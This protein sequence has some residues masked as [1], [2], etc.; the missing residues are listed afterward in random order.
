MKPFVTKTDTPT[1]ASASVADRNAPFLASHAVWA[2]TIVMVFVFTMSAWSILAP[3]SSAIVAPGVVSVE[4]HRKAVQHLEGGIVGRILVKEGTRVKTGDVLVELKDVAIVASFERLKSQYYETLAITAR[5]TSERDGLEN[6]E[7]G[8]ELIAASSSEAQARAAMAAQ[9]KIFSSRR[10]LKAERLSVLDKRIRRLEE[11]RVGARNQLDAL[12]GQ[13]D[14]NSQELRE[15]EGLFDK[16]LV[17][18]S[19]I[20]DLRRESAQLD[21]RRSRIQSTL[22]QTDQQIAELEIRKSELDSSD[23]TSIVEDIRA[24]Q[25]R[26]HEISRELIATKDV[27]SRTRIT[28]PIDGIVVGLQVHSIGGVISPGQNLMEIVPLN[29]NLVVDLR[30]RPEDIEEVRTGLPASIVL[31]TLTRRY[32][33]QIEGSIISVSADRLREERSSKPYYLVRVKIDQSTITET[34]PIAG[35]SADVFIKTGERTPLAYFTAPLVRTF[36]RGMR[37]R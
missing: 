11:E 18:K 20:T 33:Q 9:R 12:K 37:E 15:V 32:S 2:L 5:L 31:N 29:D 14:L 21:E 30:V 3:L 8:G 27:L 19:R 16:K 13:F 25:A 22:A 4:T 23:L 28:A 6:I 34:K 1:P 35:M 7:F 17:R 36:A 24:R 10:K 26:V